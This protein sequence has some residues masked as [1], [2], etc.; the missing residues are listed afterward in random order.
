ML[1][2]IPANKSRSTPIQNTTE[3]CGEPM[4][5]DEAEEA[6]AASECS[7]AFRW[8]QEERV[9]GAIIGL[10]AICFDL[11]N[12]AAIEVAREHRMCSISGFSGSFCSFRERIVQGE[13]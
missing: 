5:P 3:R 8:C 4:G 6:N 11:G 7:R 9:L 1:A 10:S 12:F 13:M 2:R